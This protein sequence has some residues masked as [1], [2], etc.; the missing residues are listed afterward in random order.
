M[1][2]PPLQDLTSAIDFTG[3]AGF[4]GS[5]LN[6]SLASQIPTDGSLTNLEGIGLTF[7]TIDT[8]LNVPNVPDPVGQHQR[9]WK[10][11][12]W[13]RVPFAGAADPTITLYSWNDSVVNDPIF[14]KW[15]T[16]RSNVALIN[17]NITNLQNQLAVTT[18]TA[19]TALATATSASTLAN[20]ANTNAT[21][22]SSQ[23]VTAQNTA[24]TA[25][26]SATNANTLAVTANTA[27]QAANVTANNALAT[28]NANKLVTQIT[29]GLAGQRIRTNSAG[30]ANE[31]YSASNTIA[32]LAEV[33][34][35]GVAGDTVNNGSFQDRTLNTTIADPG[36]LVT[37]LAAN[38][39]ILKAGTYRLK[40]LVPMTAASVKHCAR[41]Y[42]TTDGVQVRQGTNAATSSS[43]EVNAIFTTD[44][45][46][47]FKIQ[48]WTSVNTAGGL[49]CSFGLSEIY[50]YVV[51]ELIG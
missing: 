44:G 1:A 8:A 41:L 49:A 31:Y 13:A 4:D 27:A 32:T 46:K 10:R 3:L 35:T 9:R 14:F 26:T 38:A 50:T 36:A 18:D 33:Q 6:Q 20:T 30:S 17:S 48:T 2:Q 12:I 24:T 5:T 23:A 43:S 19:N 25:Q 39:F 51:I 28:A 15:V 16:T 34:A 40:A 7:P 11:Y 45:T 22:A 21:N 37:S 29:P 47:A 42:N